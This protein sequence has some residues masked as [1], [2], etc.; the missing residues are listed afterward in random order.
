MVPVSH[1]VKKGHRCHYVADWPILAVPFTCARCFLHSHP[2]L[3]KALKRGELTQQTALG[4]LTAGCHIT[5]NDA[6]E[7]AG[8]SLGMK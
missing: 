8:Q 7:E 4:T 3:S 1:L 2:F 5:M 6:E